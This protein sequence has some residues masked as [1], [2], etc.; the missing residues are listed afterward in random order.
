MLTYFNDLGLTLVLEAECVWAHVP[1]HTFK[2]WGLK[3]SLI[4]SGEVREYHDRQ[5]KFETQH[6]I[7]PP[8]PQ[9]GMSETKTPKTSKKGKTKGR[10][11]HTGL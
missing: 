8:L 7:H 1:V 10:H 2:L 6:P 3:K 4:Y 5:M 9:V 11:S